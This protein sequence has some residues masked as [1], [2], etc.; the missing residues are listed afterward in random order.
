MPTTGQPSRKKGYDGKLMTI[1]VATKF[2]NVKNKYVLERNM[3]SLSNTEIR[4]KTGLTKKQVKDLL[5]S[6]ADVGSF[7]I[8]AVIALSHFLNVP[9]N[10][11]FESALTVEITDPPTE[12]HTQPAT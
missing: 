5:T 1:K 12:S 7:P 4:R 3:A 10:Q 6:G 11:M 2:L 8:K 9:L